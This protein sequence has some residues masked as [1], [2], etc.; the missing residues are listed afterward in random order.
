MGH[1]MRERLWLGMTDAGVQPFASWPVC[2]PRP[3]RRLAGGK[4]YPPSD[5][6]FSVTPL[7][8]LQRT[9]SLPSQSAVA[10]PPRPQ[11]GAAA[12]VAPGGRI[13]NMKVEIVSSGLNGPGTLFSIGLIVCR[14]AA[15]AMASSAVRFAKACQ[16][17]ISASVR[18]SGAG[19]SGSVR[20]SAPVS[21]SRCRFSR[22]A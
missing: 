4:A 19:R 9:H 2:T 1:E 18:P 6:R 17:M 10:A 21:M 7:S 22:R 15:M 3:G 5:C 12:A 20:R 13:P 8:H 11:F 16:G 14:D